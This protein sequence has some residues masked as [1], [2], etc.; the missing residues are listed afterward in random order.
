MSRALL[1][2]RN[3]DQEQEDVAQAA[4]IIGRTSLHSHVM[5]STKYNKCISLFP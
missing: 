3:I 1:A 5:E 2:Y 4:T